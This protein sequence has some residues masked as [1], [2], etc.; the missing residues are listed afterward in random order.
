MECQICVNKM[1]I[2]K[3]KSVKCMY[4]DFEA[5]LECYR[6]YLLNESTPH[7]MNTGVCSREWTRK[8]LSSNFPQAFLSNKYKKHRENVLLEQERAMFVET[9]PYVVT[10]INQEKNIKKMSEIRKQVTELNRKYKELFNENRTLSTRVV[11]E[12]EQFVRSCP[13]NEC[14]GFLN[15]KWKCGIC[16]TKYCKDCHQCLNPTEDTTQLV[17]VDNIARDLEGIQNVFIDA[18]AAPTH[19]PTHTHVCKEDD[20]ATAKLLE[21]D[22]KSC[23]KCNMGIFKIDGCNQMFCTNCNT[24]FDW[25]SRKIMN[26]NIHNPHYFEWL[27]RQE[28]NG[29]ERR[30]NGDAAADC[31][32]FNELTNET[33]RNI[34]TLLRCKTN[35][36]ESRRA[37][38]LDKVLYICQNVLHIRYVIIRNYEYNYVESN[39]SLRIQL[40][41][42]RIS[43]KAFKI[44]IQKNE[45]KRVKSQEIYNV[46]QLLVNGVSD[47]MLRYVD[48]LR[49]PR[50]F[51]REES[52][53]ILK[54]INPIVDY[55]NECF[56]EIS[57][58]YQ[59]RL[60]TVNN[61]LYI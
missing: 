14:S 40:M 29:G 9:Q 8:F 61:V 58:T 46:L 36:T 42:N 55:A 38:I 57:A 31:P 4:C 1:N 56:R 28:T 33:S 47:I 5:C 20:L 18:G 52:E 15:Q 26:V 44:Q 7:C 22:T 27:R 30:N 48:S 53:N 51:F 2:N 21:K 34:I 25:V 23:P 17:T 37:E 49:T 50:T 45:K 59:S 13:K 16:E 60:I 12:R 54:E 11:H 19:T 39:R 35:L 43:E 10:Q 3:R 32:I 6:T 41:L 24:A